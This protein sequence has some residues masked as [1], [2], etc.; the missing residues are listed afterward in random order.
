MWR[1]SDQPTAYLMID[2]YDYI[3]QGYDYSEALRLAKLN[4]ISNPQFANPV[5]WAAFTLTG[6]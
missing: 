6:R 3:R 1:V 5:N 2:F 4:L